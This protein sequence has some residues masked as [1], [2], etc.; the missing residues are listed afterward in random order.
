VCSRKAEGPPEIGQGN[1]E[2]CLRGGNKV[3]C[4]KDAAV[5]ARFVVMLKAKGDAE[6][7]CAG[8]N[9]E[10]RLQEKREPGTSVH[11]GV[12]V[13]RCIFDCEAEARKAEDKGWWWCSAIS[14][15]V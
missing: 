7:D 15:L 13:G 14:K 4:D 10:E 8:G 2:E 12:E 6:I 5:V 1:G 3:P 9:V 11:P